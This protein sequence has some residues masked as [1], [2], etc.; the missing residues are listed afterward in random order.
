[1][2]LAN[3]IKKKPKRVK[4]AQEPVLKAGRWVTKRLCNGKEEI[5]FHLTKKVLTD[6]ITFSPAGSRVQVFR[7]T[8]NFKEAW[9]K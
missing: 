8:F 4:L 1:M 2:G 5:M 7:A 9:Q 3:S 6:Y